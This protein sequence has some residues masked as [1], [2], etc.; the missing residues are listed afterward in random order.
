MIVAVALSVAAVLVGGDDTTAITAATAVTRPSSRSGG[1]DGHDPAAARRTGPTASDRADGP[2]GHTTGPSRRSN[3]SRSSGRSSDDAVDVGTLEVPVDYDDPNG[4]TFQLSLRPPPGRRPGEQDR[5]AARQPG[6]AG[7]RRQRVRRPLPPRSTTGSCS[8]ASTSSGG[9]PAAPARASRRSTA[10]T[11]TTSTS[12]GATSRRRTTPSAS[13]LVDIAKDFA[14]EC[15]ANNG[16]ILEHVG[17]NDSA[18]DMDVDPPALGEEQI[19]YFGFSYGS[20]LGATWATLFPDTVRAVVL[21]GAADP[22]ADPVQSNLQQLRGFEGA[23]DT[24]LAQCSEDEGCAFNNDGDAD[25]VRR[26]DG[27]TRRHADPQRARPASDLNRAMAT[28]AVVQAMYRQLVLA[29]ARGI[30][31]RRPGR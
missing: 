18:R 20:E 21:D 4:P 10:S 19:S 28:V 15:V 12:P 1:D 7:I 13:R 25:G 23:L 11:T 8:S 30:A 24:F 9:I 26:A 6:R 31:G 27:A 22:D 29:G 2:A 5:L 16:D 3:R 17:T 14:E